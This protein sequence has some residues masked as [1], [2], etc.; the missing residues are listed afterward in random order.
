MKG[1]IKLENGLELAGELGDEA[2]PET[3]GEAVFF[4]GMTGYQ[5]VLSDPSYQNQILVFTYPLIGNYGINLEDFESKRPQIKGAVFYECCEAFSHYE[6]VYSLQA[7]LKK[8]KIPFLHHVDT[9]YLVK[10]IRSSGT[11][12]AKITS[13][14]AANVP[15]IKLPEHS[16]G[17]TSTHGNGIQHTVLIDFGFKKSILTA[18]I[19]RGQ[20]VTVLPYEKMEAVFDLHPDGVVFSNGP[21]DPKQLA[22]YLSAVKKIARAFP[23]LGICLGHQLLALAH[24]EDTEKL[25]FGHRGANHPV[26]DR[27]TG[28]VFMTSQNHSYVVKRNKGTQE[29]KIRFENVNDGSV[30]GLFHPEKQILSVQFHP[31]ANPGPRESEWIFD[32]YKAM[33]NQTGRV[34]IY[35]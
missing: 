26:L 11:M 1:Y 30:E 20:K 19:E 29:L 21:G 16:G 35:A 27:E 24:G 8:W 4:T 6:A 15:P 34:A 31:E 22:G 12:N 7:Y 32:E 10:N 17:E 13:V 5:E 28:K 14:P 2:Q 33:M 9:R 23:V 25:P 18:L 3:E